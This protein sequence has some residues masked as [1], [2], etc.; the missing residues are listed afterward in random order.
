M[1]A[2]LGG[3]Q[4][5]QESGSRRALRRGLLGLALLLLAAVVA[6]VQAQTVQPALPDSAAPVL[7]LPSVRLGDFDMMKQR[8]LIRILVPFSRTIYFLDKGAERGTA[9]EFGRQFETWLN[10]KYKTKSLKI[11]I[12]FIPTPRDRLLSDL[13]A[14]LGDIVA[15][16][17]TITPARQEIVDFS[18]PGMR[19]VNEVLVT[20]GNRRS[21]GAG[22]RYPPIQQLLGPSPGAQRASRRQ[23]PEGDHPDAGRRESRG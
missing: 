18:A 2:G 16:S 21:R 9:A 15:A 22:D 10:K 7:P 19:N 11:R 6:P 20:R 14:G 12:A 5:S 17:L 4:S 3:R 23:G 1:V 13:N 8:R